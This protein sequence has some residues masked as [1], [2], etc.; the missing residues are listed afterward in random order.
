MKRIV[1]ALLLVCAVASLGFTGG[2]TDKPKNTTVSLI[3][4]MGEK[5]KKDGLQMLIDG[6]KATHPNVEF[7]VTAIE[8]S[9]YLTTLKTMIAAGDT[10]DII[11]GK[12]KEYTD[13]LDAGHMADMTGASFVSNLAPGSVP[14]MV[15]KNKVYGVPVDLQTIGIFYNKK[16]FAD[17]GVKVP[18]TWNELNA[19]SDKFKAMGIAPYAHPYKD[20]WTVFVDYFADE[21]VV[22]ADY[23]EMYEQIQAGKKK[24]SD[25]PHFKETLQRLRTRAT[26]GSGDDWGTDNGTAQNMLATGKAAMY[27]MGS[28]AVG[29]FLTNFPNASIGYFPVP[30]SNDPAKNKLAIGVDDAWMAS[31]GSE[32]METVL[33]FFKYISTPEASMTW[34]KATKTI[35]LSANITGYTYD[36]I[37]Q[38]IINLLNSGNVTNFHA[39]VLFSS[40]LEDV[41][42][43]M[44]VEASASANKDLDSIVAEFDKRIAE[45]R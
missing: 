10:P 9:N 21:Y 11:F 17:N 19:A 37:S 8:T 14:S 36:P 40:A 18:T 15:Y 32:N 39:P 20:A 3:H 30:V 12:P 33:D 42:R 26:Y 22:R 45:V 34:M 5:Q 28:W 29:D 43:N 1:S 25:Y 24:F 27:V 31:A 16:V 41:Y 35:S 7:E 13:L 44:I 6:Y 2:K 38:D 4:Y 23:P